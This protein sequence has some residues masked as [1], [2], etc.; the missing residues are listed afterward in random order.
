MKGLDPNVL[1]PGQAVQFGNP[2]TPITG[3]IC[4]TI[5]SGGGHSV[6]YL[7]SWWEDDR[8][9]CTTQLDSFEV[10]PVVAE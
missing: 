5:I 1:L 10:E 9:Y 8:T 3:S 7:V 6:S 4:K 2:V